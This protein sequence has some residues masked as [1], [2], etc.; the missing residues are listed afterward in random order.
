MLVYIKHEK[1]NLAIIRKLEEQANLFEYVGNEKS[2][3]Q[4]SYR[5]GILRDR[6]IVT[7]T[8]DTVLV[9]YTI[10]TKLTNLKANRYIEGEGDD[11]KLPKRYKEV[12]FIDVMDVS[13]FRRG[14]GVGSTLLRELTKTNLPI[15][16]Q[17][18]EESEDYWYHTGFRSI[19]QSSW[20]LR[21]I[22]TTYN[23]HNK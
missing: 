1:L 21:E 2:G 4:D 12:I 10:Y 6:H 5:K 3:L 9:G 17:T 13:K 18:T 7:M 15:L 23:H 19:E 16:L 11:T 8:V 14:T 22:I 20:C